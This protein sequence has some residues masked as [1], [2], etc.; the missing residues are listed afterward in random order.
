MR[1]LAL[2]FAARIG[3]KYQIRLTRSKLELFFRISNSVAWSSNAY[4]INTPNSISIHL[5]CIAAESANYFKV[6]RRPNVNEELLFDLLRL[7]KFDKM[8]QWNILK[9]SPGVSVPS[10]IRSS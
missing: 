8:D 6:L 5:L 1:R 7:K 10:T 9:P 2:T 3:D 4:N